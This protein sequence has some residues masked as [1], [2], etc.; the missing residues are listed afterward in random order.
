M[1]LTVNTFNPTTPRAEAGGSPWV[2]ASQGHTVFFK[3]ADYRTGRPKWRFTCRG[4]PCFGNP[5]RANDSSVPMIIMWTPRT[6]TVNGWEQSWS[7]AFFPWLSALSTNLRPFAG[8]VA[9]VC[10]RSL[11]ACAASVT[12][13]WCC[14]CVVHTLCSQVT[15]KKKCQKVFSG[16]TICVGPHL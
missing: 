14:H 7:Q 10:L 9:S 8:N 16:L 1:W 3:G 4:A 6:L 11:P 15:G 12:G 2:K 13:S 5:W